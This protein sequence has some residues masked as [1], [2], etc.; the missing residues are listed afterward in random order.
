MASG[1]TVRLTANFEKNL[2]SIRAFLDE[3]G[4]IAAFQAIMDDLFDRVIP[5]LE[6]FPDIGVDFLARIPQSREG[7]ARLAALKTR[8]G[9]SVSVRE[10]IVGD[11]LILYAVHASNLYLL[12]IKHHLQLSFDLKAHWQL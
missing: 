4:A 6:R 11:Y 10:C 2:E 9:E 1:S 8:L 7:M 12:A 3:R 5:N